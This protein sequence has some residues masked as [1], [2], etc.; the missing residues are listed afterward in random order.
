MSTKRQAP[1]LEPGAD[2]DAEEPVT[3]SFLRN[4]I[5][6]LSSDLG[7]QIRDMQGLVVAQGQILTSH[8]TKLDDHT[9]QLQDCCSQVDDL[10]DRLAAQESKAPIDGSTAPPS[11]APGEV[12]PDKRPLLDLSLE[13]VTLPSSL[14]RLTFGYML[15]K[16]DLARFDVVAQPADIDLWRLLQPELECCHAAGRPADIYLWHVL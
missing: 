10:R 14:Q 16:P 3:S 2:A 9:K 4:L 15:N 1:P 6:G 5:G 8:A 11:T 13:S 7:S 12:V